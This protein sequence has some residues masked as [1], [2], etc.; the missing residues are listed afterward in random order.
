MTYKSGKNQNEYKQRQREWRDIA[1]AQL[2]ITN[3]VLLTLSTGLMAFC[4]DKLRPNEIFIDTRLNIDPIKSSYIFA[5]LLLG[6][7]IV[8]GIS[9]LFSRLYDFRISRHIS[10]ARQRSLILLPDN[11]LG[12]FNFCDRIKTLKRILFCKLPFIS[13]DEVKKLKHE[14]LVAE[15]NKLREIS[16]I[17]GS[18]T[19]RWK[20]LQALFFLFSSLT[21]LFYL[22]K[23]Q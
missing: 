2:S 11:D 3:N 17:L 21:Y 8:C 22:I 5:I 23:E 13:S 1:I 20:K 10:L 12:D 15:F 9:V 7:S 6:I 18:A 19:W 16:H 4:I 14:D